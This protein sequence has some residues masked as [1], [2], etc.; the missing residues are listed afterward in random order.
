MIKPKKIILSLEI[1]LGLS[2]ITSFIAVTLNYITY[3]E[4]KYF[5][6]AILILSSAIGIWFL[7]LNKRK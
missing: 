7:K 1:I 2:F 6:Y 3:D 4:I 5:V